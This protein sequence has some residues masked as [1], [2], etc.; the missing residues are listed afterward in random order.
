M[1]FSD[2]HN[3]IGELAKKLRRGSSVL[4]ISIRFELVAVPDFVVHS[5]IGYGN[6]LLSD[7]LSQ[8]VQW[9]FLMNVPLIRQQE[10]PML[11]GIESFRLAIVI[12]PRRLTNNLCPFRWF[13]IK[14]QFFLKFRYNN[15]L[16]H[17][18]V[19]KIQNDR[20]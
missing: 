16:L 9:A 13:T 11:I 4:R 18:S 6:E 1:V 8:K 17:C 12:L 2:M 15:K 19:D 20:S 3:F 14:R 7:K 10:I 5:L